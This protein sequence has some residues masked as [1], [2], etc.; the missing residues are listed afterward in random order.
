MKVIFSIS[1]TYH[2]EVNYADNKTIYVFILQQVYPMKNAFDQDIK[3]I[4]WASLSSSKVI[5]LTNLWE[6]VMLSSSQQSENAF[7]LVCKCHWAYKKRTAHM[8]TNNES[9]Y[10]IHEE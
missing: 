1:D 7:L 5:W 4:T 8:S 3:K 10:R 6:K 2:Y 9:Q